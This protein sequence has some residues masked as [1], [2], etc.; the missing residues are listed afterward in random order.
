MALIEYK[1]KSKADN[2]VVV[3]KTW[4]RTINVLG[5]SS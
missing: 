4:S 1:D 3:V 2:K 5:I